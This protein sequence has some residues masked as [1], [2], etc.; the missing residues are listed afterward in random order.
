MC[1]HNTLYGVF[2]FITS[3]QQP[4]ALSDVSEYQTF[5]D[6]T[7]YFHRRQDTIKPPTSGSV[8]TIV[9]EFASKILAIAV[10]FRFA[11]WQN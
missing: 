7:L 10:V 4:F 8:R 3:C 5:I 11:R 9:P 1:E 2:S 6:R